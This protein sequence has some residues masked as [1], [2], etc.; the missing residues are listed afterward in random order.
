[1][2]LW[3]DERGSVSAA[4]VYLSIAL[5]Y[6]AIYLPF[7]RADESLGLVLTFFAAL[8]TP[9]VIWAAGPRIAQ[10]LGPQAGAIVQGVAE[11]A[12]ALAEKVAA[13]RDPKS[14]L[15]ESK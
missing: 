11:S 6:Q 4:R 1:M 3:R 14:G 9:L 5:V 13:R 15:E 2:K 10:Y 8:D 7:A 12:K